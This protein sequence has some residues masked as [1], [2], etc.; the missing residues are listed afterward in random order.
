GLCNLAY[1]RKTGPLVLRSICADLS[2]WQSARSAGKGPRRLTSG[3]ARSIAALFCCHRRN[4]T[5][6]HV[7][8]RRRRTRRTS[9]GR[10]MA[11]IQLSRGAPP[12]GVRL[13]DFA[14]HEEGI[15]VEHGVIA[16]GYAIVDE[17][18]GAQRAGRA[19]PHVVGLEDALLERGPLQDTGL[20][21]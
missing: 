1:V 2:K 5:V 11:G 10:Q 6:G 14:L 19:D 21:P 13:E 12:D 7:P 16:H 3:A 20:V 4:E 8:G 18:G 9:L 15:G 17:R